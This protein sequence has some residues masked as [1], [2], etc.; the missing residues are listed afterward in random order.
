MH[1]DPMEQ[2]CVLVHR[3]WHMVNEK[4]II[5]LGILDVSKTNEL[6]VWFPRSSLVGYFPVIRFVRKLLPG[7]KSEKK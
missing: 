2:L 5:I 3:L 1:I 6:C 7:S 4:I